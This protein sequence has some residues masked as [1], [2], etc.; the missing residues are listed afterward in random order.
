MVRTDS[1]RYPRI[2]CR[3]IVDHLGPTL[4]LSAGGLRVLTA[5]PAPPGAEV[6][7]AFQ[8]PETELQLHCHGR[9]VHVLRSPIDQ[10]LFEIGIQFQRMMTRH[11][12]AIQAYVGER[13]DQRVPV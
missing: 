11:R 5:R 9:V 3:V 13:V 12:A 6:Q 7:L 2:K 1:R 4:D 10:D 8:M